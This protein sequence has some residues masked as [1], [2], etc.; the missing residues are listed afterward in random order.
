M[1]ANCLEVRGFG[2]SEV[3][4][5]GDMWGEGT[6]RHSFTPATNQISPHVVSTLRSMRQPRAYYCQV[7]VC[8]ITSQRACEIRALADCKMTPE[9]TRSHR[10]ITTR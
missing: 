2:V 7:P 5:F 4:W 1:E 9:L 10:S 3:W 8:P 6:F